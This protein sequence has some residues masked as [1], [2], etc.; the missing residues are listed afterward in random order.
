M[1]WN[2]LPC[3]LLD[4]EGTEY[5]N[6][7][8]VVVQKYYVLIYAF[9]CI[10]FS[11]RRITPKLTTVVTATEG[12]WEA[13]AGRRGRITIHHFI[14]LFIYLFIWPMEVPRPRIQFMQL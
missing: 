3:I 5:M 4:K 2:G 11:L 6:S 7:I 9:L 12:N 13:G 10:D 14:Y 1:I 8:P